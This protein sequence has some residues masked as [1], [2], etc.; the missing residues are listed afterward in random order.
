M[1]FGGSFIVGQPLYSSSEFM[2]SACF[3]RSPK[4][5]CMEYLII[6]SAGSSF[7]AFVLEIVFMCV[8][9]AGVAA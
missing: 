1:K 8:G 9:V 5:V 6:I 4:E 7:S 2:V 3:F